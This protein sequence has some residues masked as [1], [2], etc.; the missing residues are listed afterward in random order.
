MFEDVSQPIFVSFNPFTTFGKLLISFLHLWADIFNY[1]M[2]CHKAKNLIPEVGSQPTRT[3][4][5]VLELQVDAVYEE[6]RL[7]IMLFL[8]LPFSVMAIVRRL[9]LLH[10]I[11]VN[12]ND[13]F[14]KCTSSLTNLVQLQLE[15]GEISNY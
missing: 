15:F 1:I 6:L 7:Y 12:C 4:E 9:C 3:G 10:C 11:T 13:F 2:Q 5:A 8:L 14:L